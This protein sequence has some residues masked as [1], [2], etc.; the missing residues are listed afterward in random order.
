[1]L[2][3][4]GLMLRSPRTRATGL[5][6]A[7]VALLVATTAQ[8]NSDRITRGE[9]Q[10]VFAAAQTGG[11]AI[12]AHG[13]ALQGAPAAITA[14]DGVRINA[15]PPW[16]GRHYCSLDWH[17][18]SINL[19]AGN[20]EG[21]SFTRTELEAI[22]SAIEV[23]FFLDDVLHDT[24]R[25][26]IRPNQY[27][28]TGFSD[29]VSVTEGRVMSPNDLAVGSHTL[30]IVLTD[31]LAGSSEITFFVDPADSGTCA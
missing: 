6:V 14:N 23:D 20:A 9:A 27:G 22:L 29:T 8:A 7:I 16:E 3:E 24:P 26:P 11:G 13:G 19:A 25:T 15:F 18:I 5:V 1:M 4:R 10:A 17:V 12:I 30:R 31:P 28:P 2:I 21:E